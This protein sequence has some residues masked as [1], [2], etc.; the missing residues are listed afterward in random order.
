MAHRVRDDHRIAASPT[1]VMLTTNPGVDRLGAENRG[2][3]DSDPDDAGGGDD[4]DEGRLGPWPGMRAAIEERH[5]RGIE[6]A[7][8]LRA[9][10]AL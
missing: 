2:E 9:S 3:D 8:R 1:L 10:S 6:L 4:A 5:R 7:R